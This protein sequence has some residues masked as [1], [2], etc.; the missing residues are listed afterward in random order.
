MNI[1]EW[2]EQYYN[3]ADRTKRK[4]LLDKRM[5]TGERSDE[6]ELIQKL[7]IHRYTPEKKEPETVDHMLRGVLF[8]KLTSS[9]NNAFFKISK[10]DIK[11]I[12]TD[13]GI[14]IAKEYGKTGERTLYLELKHV[15]KTYFTT[16]ANDRGYNSYIWGIGQ[17]S[18]N[19]LKGKLSH[20][21]KILT[22][23]IP[24]AIGLTEELKIF[25][26]AISDAFFECVK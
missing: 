8:L 21:A 22:E 24:Q 2:E 26:Q 9:R 14:E 11:A 25:T 7:Y 10:K 23:D 13:L 12:F 18:D 3:E 19:A 16:C 15:G 20:D 5:E 1:A 6:L 17:L 4:E